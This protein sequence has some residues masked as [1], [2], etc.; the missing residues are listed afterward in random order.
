MKNIN[1]LIAVLLLTCATVHAQLVS[2]NPG[3]GQ[4]GQTLTTTVTASGNVFQ[5]STSNGNILNIQLRKFGYD[6]I[7]V[8]TSTV[9]IIDGSHFSVDVIIPPAAEKGLYDLAIK[10]WP[11]SYYYT[12]QNAFRVGTPDGTVSGHVYY[13][14]NGNGTED[15]GEPALANEKIYVTPDNTYIYTDASGNYSLDTYNGSRTITWQPTNQH[16]YLLSSANPSYTVVVNNNNFPGNDFGLITA[17]TSITPNLANAGETLTT[18]ITGDNI[19]LQ[20]SSPP[21]NILNFNLQGGSSFNVPYSACVVL[22]S[23]TAEVTMTVYGAAIVGVYDVNVTVDNPYFP[24]DEITYPCPE[25]FNIGPPDGYVDGIIYFDAD[26]NGVMDPGEFGIAY[27]N[28]NIAP[29]NNTI[30]PGG[31]GNFHFGVTN[32]SHTVEVGQLGEFILSSPDTAYIVTINN[33]TASGLDFGLKSH[34]YSIS[35]N[36]GYQ[37]QALTTTITG[38]E[39]Q[40]QSSSPQGNIF[41]MHLYKS[42]GGMSIAVPLANIIQPVD[43]IHFDAMIPVPFNADT[44]YYDVSV[45]VMQQGAPWIHH[46]Y[47]LPHGF[48]VVKAD[49][50]ISGKI[51]FDADSNKVFSAGDMEMANERVLLMPDNVYAFSD[52]YGNYTFGTYNGSHT[53]AWNPVA[54]GMFN[55]LSDSA[56]YTVNANNNTQSGF[57]FGLRSVNEY[58]TSEI[59]LTN[60]FPRCNTDVQYNVHYKNLSNHPTNGQIIV[61]KAPSMTFVSAV[62][63]PT[64]V[65]GDTITWDYTNLL[66][67]ATANIQIVFH[68]PAPGNNIQT[69]AVITAVD[70]GNVIQFSD[71]SLTNPTI[72]CSWDPNDKAVTP[73]GVQ[74]QNYTLFADVLDYTVRFQNTG[75]DTA[76]NVVIIDTLSASLDLAT[77]EVIAS[78]HSV[79][80]ELKPSGVVTFTFNNIMLPDSNVNELASHGFVRYRIHALAGLPANTVITNT[81]NIF[82]DLN[83]PVA[84]N[85]TTNTMVYVIPTAI[86]EPEAENDGVIIYPNPFDE[87]AVLKF[88]NSNRETYSLKIF[89]AVGETVREARFK[90]N[91]IL[92]RKQSLAPGLYFYMLKNDSGKN[93][94]SSKFVIK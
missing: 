87:T 77:F 88:N 27:G 7:F 93:S 70:G 51:F 61:G 56:S 74:N 44:G 6:T 91:E 25:C 30:Y 38:F 9:N 59:I 55:L 81:A 19:F 37:G 23:N 36:E 17:I 42:G 10:V 15:T 84:T 11:N 92:L 60:N 31:N 82:F 63:A 32:G 14:T 58:Y 16:Y 35:P 62:P 13:D 71:T 66:P 85:T 90:S 8:D 67:L 24:F 5:T 52:D 4:Q 26:T 49:A 78:S 45:T 20:T 68:L 46:T 39:T 79:Q 28:L 83:E 41:E 94:F 48:H 47:V 12:L 40:F 75:T 21:G 76:F 33:N 18:T 86:D 22:D 43:S 34:L 69:Q 89:N 3:L 72:S 73:P 64:L 50:F 80:T 65:Q 29:E 1:I 53:V 54:G 57:D 2:M